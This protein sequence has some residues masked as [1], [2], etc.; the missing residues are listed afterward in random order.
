MACDGMDERESMKTAPLTVL[1]V[2]AQL[3]YGAGRY[4]ADTAIEQAAGLGHRV[5]VCVSR[6]V[7]DSW[8][9]DPVLLAELAGRNIEV[10]MAGD[11]FHRDPALIRDAGTRIGEIRS[12]SPGRVIVHAHTAMAAAAGHWA[13]PDGLVVTCHGWGAGRPMEIDLQDSLAYQLCGSVVTY[14]HHWAERLIHDLGVP[15]PQIVPMGLDLRRFPPLPRK[16][17]PASDP[18]RIITVCELTHRKGV[19]LL[20]RAM[21]AVW[22]H[23]PRAE[24][25]I[26]GHGD[27]ACGLRAMARELDPESQRIFFHGAVKNPYLQLGNFDLFVLA[28]RSDNLPAVLLEAMLARLPIV[29]TGVGG[30]PELIAAAGCGDIVPPDSSEALAA[31]ILASAGL[32]PAK[33]ASLGCRGERFC[34]RHYD[35]RKTAAQLEP[36]YRAAMRKRKLGQTHQD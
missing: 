23:L 24:L 10:H 15:A 25:H 35:V 33:M 21:P 17:A 11:F 27:A 18:L 32:G 28:S 12:A 8:R 2:I 6:D 16:P 22:K 26:M 36:V 14:S 4:L 31:R 29:A 9:T 3:R 20:I 13:R 1:H 19:D 30:A 34:R 7:D 5:A